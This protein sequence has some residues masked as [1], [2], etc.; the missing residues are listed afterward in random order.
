MLTTDQKVSGL[1]PDGVTKAEIH[2]H[3]GFRLL[4]SLL[5][6]WHL[7]FT[8]NKNGNTLNDQL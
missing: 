5:V 3:R 7:R 6:C 8:G 1:N 4:F 2:A